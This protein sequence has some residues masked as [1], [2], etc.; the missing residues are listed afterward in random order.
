MQRIR[1]RVRK[2]GQITLPQD[3]RNRWEVG[4]GSE[5][6]LV[7]EGNHAVISPIR[8]TKVREDAGSLGQADKDEVDIAIMD[9][10]LVSSHY[11]KKYRR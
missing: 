9:P 6:A 2:K 11:L 7:E 5:L 4:E 3:L 1:I 10:E 8:R